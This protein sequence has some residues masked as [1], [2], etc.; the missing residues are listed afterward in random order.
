MSETG[1]YSVTDD[2]LTGLCRDRLRLLRELAPNLLK[3]SPR[4]PR[5]Q[6]LLRERRARARAIRTALTRNADAI[7]S[8]CF[9]LTGVEP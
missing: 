6:D 5:R 2:E 4:N 3:P 7:V 9:T 1:T 8:R